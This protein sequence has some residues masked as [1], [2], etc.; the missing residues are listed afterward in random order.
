M[1][2]DRF[3]RHL[4]AFGLLALASALLYPAAQAGLRFEVWGLLAVIVLANLLT[5]ATP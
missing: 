2:K 5:L 3:L 4:L 1:L